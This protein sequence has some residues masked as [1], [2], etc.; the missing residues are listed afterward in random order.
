MPHNIHIIIHKPCI[1][2]TNDR[3]SLNLDCLHKKEPY[4]CARV[5]TDSCNS[6]ARESVTYCKF[7]GE[8]VSRKGAS[9]II[10]MYKQNRRLIKLDHL[11][12]YFPAVA[13]S[14]T[15]FTAV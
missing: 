1:F 11:Y 12:I 4:L 8:G 3:K 2:R 10:T 13:V 7:S 5:S 14:H 6:N 9:I 15:G